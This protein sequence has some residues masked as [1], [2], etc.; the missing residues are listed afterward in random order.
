MS[1]C[2]ESYKKLNDNYVDFRNQINTVVNRFVLF[3]KYTEKD[4]KQ[5]L[6]DISAILEEH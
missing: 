3:G 1:D 5:A 6:A 2:E 4:Y